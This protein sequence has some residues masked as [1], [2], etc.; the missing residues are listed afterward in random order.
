MSLQCSNG[1]ENGNSWKV[2]ALVFS[3]KTMTLCNV[4]VEEL[5]TQGIVDMVSGNPFPDTVHSM[6]TYL[7]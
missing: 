7:G 2:I 5:K 6:N 3:V 1:D 4:Q